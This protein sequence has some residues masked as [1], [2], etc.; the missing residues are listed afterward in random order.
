MPLPHARSRCRPPRTKPPTGPLTAA[1]LS[2]IIAG[3]ALLAPSPGAADAPTPLGV[4]ATEGGKSHIEIYRCGA[5]MCGKIVWLNRAPS[6]GPALDTENPDPDKQGRP[7]L[8]MRVLS[9]LKPGSS[10][11][12]WT[13]G[14][15][16][17]PRD[18]ES[19]SVKM[20][21]QDDGRLRV[22]GYIGISLLGRS[23]TWTRAE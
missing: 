11:R 15:V 16:Y 5:N 10:P 14:R 23:Q 9:A 1:V 7:I 13:G 21:L 18:G 6:R 19:Y 8:G 3:G 17:D 2:A 22:R 4:W 20:T 12:E